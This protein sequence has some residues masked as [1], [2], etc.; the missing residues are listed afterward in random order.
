MDDD[1]K[2]TF[3]QALSLPCVSRRMRSGILTLDKAEELWGEASCPDDALCY[4]GGFESFW[5]EV[6]ELPDTDDVG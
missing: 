5:G 4:K 2:A 3:E 1:D 6:N